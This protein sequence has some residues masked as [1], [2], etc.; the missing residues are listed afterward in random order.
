MDWL[1]DHLGIFVFVAIIIASL[2]QK[3]KKAAAQPPPRNVIDADTSERTRRLQEEIR[4]KIAER[5]GRTSA[6]PRPA[7]PPPL[8]AEEQRTPGIFEELARQM[9]EARKNAEARTRARTDEQEARQR[10]AAEQRARDLAEAELRLAD[11]RRAQV[12]EQRLAETVAAYGVTMPSGPSQRAGLLADLR[13]AES[14]RRAL[15]LR[16]VLGPP[17]G[18]R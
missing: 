15:V 18:L 14:L 12:Q 10:A 17:L 3:L 16:E 6:G 13:G 9:A 4:R 2:L 1:F 7:A 8:P 5:T 11:V